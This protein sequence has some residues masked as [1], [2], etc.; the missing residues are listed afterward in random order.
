MH[1]LHDGRPQ[2]LGD[3]ADHLRIRYTVQP[4]ARKFPAHDVGADLLLGFFKAPIIGVF[5]HQHPQ[6][7]LGR[8]LLAPSCPALLPP[9]ALSLVDRLDHF[10]V[11]QQPIGHAHPGW[12]Q[13]VYLARPET[14]AQ[15]HLSLTPLD[16]A[17]S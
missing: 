4:H 11:F 16:H 15:A 5:E 1:L 12:P 10:F 6:H 13:I 7:D 14:V 17:I 2:Q 9:L 3:L 8:G